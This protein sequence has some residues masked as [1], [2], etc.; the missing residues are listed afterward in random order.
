MPLE[1]VV[2]PPND[3]VGAGSTPVTIEVDG[4]AYTLDEV[5][6]V[7]KERVSLS[8]RAQ[9]ADE[10]ATV[11]A[12]QGMDPKDFIQRGEGAWNLA[13]QLHD[14]GVIDEKGRPIVQRE[15][16]FLPPGPGS[17]APVEGRNTPPGNEA[18]EVIAR[19]LLG[20]KQV[21]DQLL[22]RLFEKEVKDRY[23][24][25]G[26]DEIAL[27]TTKA[28]NEKKDFWS[29]AEEFKQGLGQRASAMEVEFAKK[30]GLDIEALKRV[31]ALKEQ[32]GG[33]GFA[34]P[35]G[36]KISFH[37]GKDAITPAQAA[38]AYLESRGE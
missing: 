28:I 35:P 25:F 37:G 15:E 9:L 2:T 24:E 10:L 29:V 3:G 30:Y 14:A 4:K 6:G 26:K 11:A 5:K 33:G 1:E 12:R 20:V 38:K 22:T 7:L 18:L 19:E 21:N 17:K 31:H 27:V 36:K 8:Q 32:G 34:L 16:S 23:P 13:R